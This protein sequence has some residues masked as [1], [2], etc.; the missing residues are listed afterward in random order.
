ML[1]QN[2]HELEY[3]L[4]HQDLQR[5]GVLGNGPLCILMIYDTHIDFELGVRGLGNDR[6]SFDNSRM[7][8]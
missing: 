7:F 8:H 1:W 3:T 5:L 4:E 6:E 2:K